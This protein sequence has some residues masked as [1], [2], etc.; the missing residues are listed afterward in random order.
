MV[1]RHAR[2]ADTVELDHDPDAVEVVLI[3]GDGP[4]TLA[5]LAQHR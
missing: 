4:P 3:A 2:E 1:R 5:N